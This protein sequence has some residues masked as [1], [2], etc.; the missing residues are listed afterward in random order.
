MS[1]RPALLLSVLLA[2]AVALVGCTSDGDDGGSVSYQGVKVT[3]ANDLK[4]EPQVTSKST[5]APQALQYKDLV[6]GTGKPATPTSNVEVQYTGVRYGDGLKFDSSWS[7]GKPAAF[8]LQGVIP[9]FTDGI[10]GKG[11]TPAM[12]EGGRR[13]MILPA[14]LAYGQGGAGKD[15]PPNTPLVF[16]VDLVKVN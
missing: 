6:V 5:D 9:G 15:I 11:T 1:K 7:G 13:L 12:K 14:A 4:K 3:N 16:V 8:S 2:A 10:A